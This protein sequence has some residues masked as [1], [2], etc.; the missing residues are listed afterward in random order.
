MV[1][2][3]V[4]KW[5]R[6][7]LPGPRA[8]RNGTACWV[9]E[10][11]VVLGWI[12]SQGLG[13][14]VTLREAIARRREEIRAAHTPTVT[15]TMNS[16]GGD[17]ASTTALIISAATVCTPVVIVVAVVISRKWGVSDKPSDDTEV[18]G[19][20]GEMDG[21]PAA[22]AASATVRTAPTVLAA[23]HRR[24][25]T[26]LVVVVVVVAVISAVD[27]VRG[28]TKARCEPFCAG[29]MSVAAGPVQG[30]EPIIILL[31]KIASPCTVGEQP[32]EEIDP[33]LIGG[34]MHRRT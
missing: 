27:G 11:S 14:G 31:V 9:S 23:Q 12:I 13:I 3:S 6:Q 33:A 21:P 32:E 20:A 8:P 26:A 30:R 15:T 24:Q 16:S 25:Q 7:N 1:K 4:Q 18:A 28:R 34:M 29:Q 10:A 19:L 5:F 17:A 2:R 22:V